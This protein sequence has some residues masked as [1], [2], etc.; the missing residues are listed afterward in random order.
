MV[1]LIIKFL[2]DFPISN[3]FA[4]AVRI[5][6]LAHLNNCER[7]AQTFIFNFIPLPS[8]QHFP[9]RRAEA[10]IKYPYLQ[11][12]RAFFLG[13]PIFASFHFFLK[14]P[15]E[16]VKNRGSSKRRYVRRL[17]RSRR[18]SRDGETRERF[19]FD[20]GIAAFSKRLLTSGL[21]KPR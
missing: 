4:R 17:V 1:T 12:P 11:H 19:V 16:R 6:A 2:P 9:F 8:I 10:A 13:V 5:I 15:R 21:Y 7:C 20:L 14:T 3:V 18:R